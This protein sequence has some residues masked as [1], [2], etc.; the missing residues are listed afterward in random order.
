MAVYGLPADVAQNQGKGVN[1]YI[2]GKTQLGP[3][4]VFLGGPGTGVT[5]DMLNGSVR[6]FGDT[7]SQTAKAFDAYANHQ[8]SS[9]PFETNNV[10]AQ[11]DAIIASNGAARSDWA[12]GAPTMARLALESGQAQNAVGNAQN[13]AQLTGIFNN[14]DTMAKKAYNEQIRQDAIKN[15]QFDKTLAEHYASLRA[16]TLGNPGGSGSSGGT[17]APTAAQAKAILEGSAY[18]EI[19]NQ[20][21]SGTSPDTVISSITSQYG[22]LVGQG[23][24]PDQM[25]KYIQDHSGFKT[26][27]DAS[28]KETTS[29]SYIPLDGSLES[30][31]RLGGGSI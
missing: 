22:S 17:K 19:N 3:Q 18:D 24:N 9:S 25:I 28:G 20:L 8:S 12:R 5:D 14:Q 15:S 30:L 10:Q 4:D 31:R 7:A 2:P 23:L 21:S 26:K 27:T 29:G 16:G 1:L 13:A 6:V 11:R